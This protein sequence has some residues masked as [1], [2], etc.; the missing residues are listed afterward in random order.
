MGH[1]DEEQELHYP[2]NWK[3]EE[4]GAGIRPGDVK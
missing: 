1:S 3:Q 2:P 4:A